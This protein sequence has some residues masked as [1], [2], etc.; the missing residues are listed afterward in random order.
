MEDKMET[1]PV[2]VS[3]KEI[4]ETLLSAGPNGFHEIVSGFLNDIGQLCEAMDTLYKKDRK[5]YTILST[6]GVLID[7]K[8]TA[9]SFTQKDL[10]QARLGACG[11]GNKFDADG[12][13]IIADKASEQN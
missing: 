12:N 3:K 5:T 11:I 13:V 7:V 8:V 6:M 10:F 2:E 9:N 1:T 4:L